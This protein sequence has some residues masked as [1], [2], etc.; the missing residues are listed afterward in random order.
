MIGTILVVNNVQNT[1]IMPTCPPSSS[2]VSMT[3][4]A[5]F[6]S[7]IILQKSPIVFVMGACVTM[8]A[9]RWR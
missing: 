5:D 8:N 3:L 9:I 7:Q 6:C 1:P 2:S 4:A